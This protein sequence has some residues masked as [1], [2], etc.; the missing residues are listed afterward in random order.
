[1]STAPLV[2]FGSVAGLARCAMSDSAT[3]CD[4]SIEIGPE[5]RCWRSVASTALSPGFVLPNAQMIVCDVALFESAWI[6]TRGYVSDQ[7]SDR[8]ERRRART[9]I[10]NDNL[11]SVPL[12]SL[13]AAS[14]VATRG[15]LGSTVGI[16]SEGAFRCDSVMVPSLFGHMMTMG[17]FAIVD[18][19][20][21][22]RPVSGGVDLPILRL[23]SPSSRKLRYPCFA[24]H[25]ERDIRPC[26]GS[27]R[28]DAPLTLN[29]RA[30][31]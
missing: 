4:M 25:L 6:I 31:H 21:L 29:S 15:G 27:L 16:T 19:K 1:M 22:K 10:V 17:V 23:T 8:R 11:G 14:A 5:L 20:P 13:A 26:R 18:P 12:R 24:A 30:V 7:T 28:E 3:T 9:G 2:E